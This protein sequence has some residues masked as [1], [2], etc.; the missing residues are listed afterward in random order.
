MRSKDQIQLE[1]LYLSIHQKRMIK[2][3]VWDTVKS[4]GHLALDIAGLFPGGGEFADVTNAVWYALE[5]EYLNSALSLISCIPTLGDAIGKGGKLAVWLSKAGKAGTAIEKGI[6]K[7]SPYVSNVKNLIKVN[8]DSIDKVLEAGR[9]NE[10]L[11]P[12]IDK[13]KEALNIFAGEGNNQSASVV[14]NAPPVPGS[15]QATA[16]A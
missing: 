8:R 14:T 2:E 13:M 4:V 15:A 10:K 12:H 1:N 3:G 9:K 6:V 5:G 16:A 7:A 11:A